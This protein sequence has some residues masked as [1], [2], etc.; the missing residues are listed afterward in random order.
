MDR[1]VTVFM[2]ILAA[3]ILLEVGYHFATLGGLTGGD[4]HYPSPHEIAREAGLLPKPAPQPPKPSIQA[5]PVVPSSAPV[6][7]SQTVT[8]PR[9]TA[10]PAPK[11]RPRRAA[12]SNDS[13][14]DGVTAAPAAPTSPPPSAGGDNSPPF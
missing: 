5:P 2:V 3:A 8:Q 1:P 9:P 11:H 10:P 6:A 7:A 4:S 12:S 13:L 14:T